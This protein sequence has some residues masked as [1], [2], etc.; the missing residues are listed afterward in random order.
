MFAHCK[1]AVMEEPVEHAGALGRMLS[2]YFRDPDLNS[3]E[4]SNYRD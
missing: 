1:V 4:V 2:V 3:V